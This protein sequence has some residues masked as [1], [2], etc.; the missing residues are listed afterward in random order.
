MKTK[1]NKLI[2]L[3][4]FVVSIA[5][6]PQQQ[7]LICP[8]SPLRLVGADVQNI[9]VI[10]HEDSGLHGTSDEPY[11][12]NVGFRVTFGKT[13]STVAQNMTP[14]PCWASVNWSSANN[15]DAVPSPD[16]MGSMNCVNIQIILNKN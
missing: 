1:F 2:M 8:P 7:D 11:I 12:M 13:C 5:C 16:E 14:T 6:T 15:G 9:K 3:V 4:I 10:K